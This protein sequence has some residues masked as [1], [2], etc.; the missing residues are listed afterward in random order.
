MNTYAS[1]PCSVEPLGLD[2]APQ[3]EAEML[4]AMDAFRPELAV[5]EETRE[6]VHWIK[7]PPLPLTSI[8][9]YTILFQSALASIPSEYRKLLALGDP[10]LSTYQPVTTNLLR[11]IRFAIGP[12]SPIEDA[13][14]ERLHRAGVMTDGKVVNDHGSFQ[15][16]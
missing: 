7:N 4:A 15:M 5:T 2:K 8:P 13:A 6:I 14:I 12:E 10:P 1:G 9:I 11:F 3:N 16:T